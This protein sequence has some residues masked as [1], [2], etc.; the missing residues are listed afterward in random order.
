MLSILDLNNIHIARE[1]IVAGSA[2]IIS[3]TQHVNYAP[4]MP[5]IDASIH[6][7]VTRDCNDERALSVI[8][9][10]TSYMRDKG[11]SLS[12][13][14]YKRSRSLPDLVHKHADAYSYILYYVR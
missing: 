9:V 8:Y 5:L 14:A 10:Y 1:Y 13:R 6:C 7:D 2:L 12:R 11:Q 4:T 3:E